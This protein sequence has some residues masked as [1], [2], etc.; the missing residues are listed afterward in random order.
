[1]EKKRSLFTFIGL[2]VLYAILAGVNLFLPQGPAVSTI[3]GGLPAPTPVIALA[4]AGFVLVLYGALGLAGFFLA[5]K[6]GL[7]ELWD[8]RITNRQRFLIPV[9]LGAGLGVF[10]II[11]DL[12]FS[13]FNGVGRIPHPLFPTSL[14]AALGAG[15]GEEVL[16]RLFF[17]SLWTWLV[18]GLI[19]RG[20]SQTPVYWVVSVFSALAFSMAH[21]GTVMLLEGWQSIAQIPP[22]FW[23]ELILIN[24]S[25][26]M[27]AAYLFRKYGFLASAGVHFWADVAWHVVWGAI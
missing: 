14:V 22:A 27:V 26:G 20:R 2:I 13:T 25:L 1:M 23:V 7:P 21:A 5:R 19:L 12:A 15:I 4:Q 24:G 3:P 17:I 9:L 11:L 6:L 16:F 10:F 8:E 18:S